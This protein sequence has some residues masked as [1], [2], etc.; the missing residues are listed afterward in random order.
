MVNM[1]TTI[2]KQGNYVKN[3]TELINIDSVFWK[4]LFH[5]IE[6]GDKWYVWIEQN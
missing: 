2:T 5:E 4:G 1:P 6:I 3:S